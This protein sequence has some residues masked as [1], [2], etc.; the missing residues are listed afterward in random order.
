MRR[1]F[2][3]LLAAAVVSSM[4][5]A[6]VAA[7]GN[8]VSTDPQVSDDGTIVVESLFSLNGGYLVVHLDQGGQPGRPVGV[9]ELPQGSQSNFEVGIDEEYWADHEGNRTY[10]VVLHRDADETDGAFDPMV[11]SPVE[12]LHGGITG[13]TIPIRKS[14]DGS[15][16]V[17]AAG[18]DGQRIDAPSL[19]L[20][21]VDLDRPGHV[22]VRSVAQGSPADVVG[23]RSLDPGSYENVSVDLDRSFFDSLTVDGSQSLVATLH[24]ADGDGSF[25]ADSDDPLMAG[26]EAVSTRFSVTKVADEAATTEPL[27]NTPEPTDEPTSR[28]TGTEPAEATTEDSASGATPGFG[29]VATLLATVLAAAVA[30]GDSR[31]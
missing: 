29:L 20:S 7:H 25:R 12:G 21:R 1:A 24:V 9:T 27:V 17:T 10:W 4:V 31:D 19:T 15:A 3:L 14:G 6:P 11:D 28:A 5:A 23:S 22:V 30:R 16:R 2:A 18:Y 26:E 8:H 13:S